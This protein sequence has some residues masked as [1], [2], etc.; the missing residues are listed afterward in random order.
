M[1][2]GKIPTSNT[3]RLT[4]DFIQ[5]QVKSL[6]ALAKENQIFKENLQNLSSHKNYFTR[7][8]QTYAKQR[9]RDSIISEAFY[10]HFYNVDYSG[11]NNFYKENQ[12]IESLK[13]DKDIH[14]G[15]IGG[16][17][18][19]YH[20]AQGN[21]PTFTGQ[22]IIT[23]FVNV[24]IKNITE[25]KLTFDLAKKDLI[26]NFY[27]FVSQIILDTNISDEEA[28]KASM[29]FFKQ[30]NRDITALEA[31]EKYGTQEGIDVVKNELKLAKS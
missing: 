10:K 17:F 5:S 19:L 24:Q 18:V 11:V 25:K 7:R 21:D 29:L 27:L 6:Q 2:F 28:A 22:D 14:F 23:E 13:Q 4:Q 16:I 1:V 9:A 8:I 20:Q 15:G 3:V 30:E 26:E 12:I 31:I